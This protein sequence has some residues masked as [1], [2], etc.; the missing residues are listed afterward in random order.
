[1]SVSEKG[2]EFIDDFVADDV[3]ADIKAELSTSSFLSKG[4]GIRNADKKLTTVNT[5]VSSDWLREKAEVYLS[6]R[7]SVV[8]VILFI[9]VPGNNW[10]VSWHQDKTVAVSQRFQRV[11]WG[12]WSVKDGV[13]HV[14]PTVDVLEQMVSFRIHLDDSTERNGCLK[15][16]PNSHKEGIMS[17]ESIQQYSSS[18]RPVLC[19]AKSGS[20]LVM[21]PHVL[22]ASSKAHEP[23]LRRVLHVEY[24]SYSLPAGVVWA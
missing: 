9:K 23:S 1:M 7:A 8:R 16:L 5:L 10:L 12:P 14:Q 6:G 3:I 24:S 15:L 21:R 4:G 13:T 22:H 11:N 2:F 20:A 19:E 18:H 17:Q